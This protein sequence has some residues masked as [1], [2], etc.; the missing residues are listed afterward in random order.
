M[1]IVKIRRGT[2]L[3]YHELPIP[4]EDKMGLGQFHFRGL[5]TLC[6]MHPLAT[7]VL[8]GRHSRLHKAALRTPL[9]GLFAAM[10][11]KGC[12]VLKGYSLIPITWTIIPNQD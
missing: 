8:W 10:V 2:Q 12:T 4:S 9:G 7:C 1:L 3:G 6:K 11:F 5:C